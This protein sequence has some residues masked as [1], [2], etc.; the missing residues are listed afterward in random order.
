MTLTNTTND[1]IRFR[2]S[3]DNAKRREQKLAQARANTIIHKSIYL[4]KDA[5]DPRPGF[6]PQKGGGGP[7]AFGYEWI[8]SDEPDG[9]LYDWVDISTTGTMLNASSP[10]V[11]SGTLSATDEG[12]IQVEL[13]F[14]FPFYGTTY[15]SAYIG[16]NGTLSFEV[17][18]GSFYS[19]GQIPSPA[20][21][22][23]LID[24]FIAG[25]WDD[26]DIAGNG[27]M[28]YGMHNGSFVLQCVNLERYSSTVADYT[29]EFI[30]R[31]NGEVIMQYAAMGIGGG[32]TNSATIGIENGNGTVGLQVVSSATYLHNELA[33]RFFLPD[34]PWLSSEPSFGT[35][36]PMSAA[37]VQ[38]HLDASELMLDTTYNAQL[39]V[40]AVHPD[41]GGTME[42]PVH[43]YVKLA[44]SALILS[45]RNTV[46][47]G[48]VPLFETK[49][50]SIRIKNGGLLPL[51]VSAVTSTNPFFAVS[52]NSFNLEPGAA[53]MVFVDYHPFIAHEDTGRVI[54][55]S[56]SQYTPRI[57]VV[58]HGN[59]VGVAHIAVSP[60]SF[61]A[62]T[63]A[64]GDTISYTM[65]VKNSGTDTLHFKINELPGATVTEGRG[66]P[67]AFGYVWR[68]N[69]DADGPVFNWVD[70]RTM[71]TALTLADNGVSS[72]VPLGFSFNYYGTSYNE[73]RV[74]AN[75]F[76]SFTTTTSYSFNTAVPSVSMP[77]NSLYGF[78]DDLNPATTGGEVHYYANDGKFTVQYTNVARANNAGS[79]VTFQIILLANG[80][81]IYQY[82]N[83]VGT[84]NS[85]TVGME[86][87]GGTTGLQVVYNNTYIHNNLA[88]LFTQD[89]ISWLSTNKLDGAV[90][91]GDS[92][93]VKVQIH[94][95]TTHP[96][97]YTA[98]LRVTGNSFDTVFA[99]VALNVL[100]GVNDGV[101]SSVP[102]K[103]SLEQNYPNP[104]NPSTT[105]NY[106]LPLESL[107]R[108]RIFD[109][110]GKEIATLVRTTQA[111]GYYDVVWNAGN[112]ASGLYFYRL[113]ATP[114][115][116]SVPFTQIKKMLLMK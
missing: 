85:A 3:D 26:L 24:N 68:D 2:V 44:D 30:L 107:V 1:S 5:K 112:V 99:S 15:T 64:T 54:F 53:R 33:I 103:F 114:K 88:V 60:N 80:E 65:S 109:I 58:L 41:A 23:A 104:F 12:T 106:S 46:E 27:V 14:P 42:I 95:R 7:D 4:E 51:S 116:G 48:T 83:V 11:A 6:A 10:W 22:S 93:R 32:V 100:T 21:G 39:F 59:S 61:S 108:L 79:R 115:N 102:T 110:L 19:N 62:T 105:L 47:F 84:L 9:P 52:A 69:E 16:T 29:F 36:P 49:R 40:D 20:S 35:I 13:P 77:N 18:T 89:R 101:I 113:D 50:D 97:N 8:D 38:V 87:S 28:Y 71:G 91:P 78:W 98:K 37:N 67:D 73:L 72:A 66:G 70:I 45:N 25:F 57:D 111:A 82:A 17:P 34:A 74:F 92:A 81:I 31:P 86:N 56:N 43:L 63:Q 55:I 96:G 94:P 75:G 90:F 76:L